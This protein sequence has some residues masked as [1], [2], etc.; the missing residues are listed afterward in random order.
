M[1]FRDSTH[2]VCYFASEDDGC[3]DYL[4]HTM[5]VVF[6]ADAEGC[7]E[8]SELLHELGHYALG[9]PMHANPRWSGLEAEFAPIVWDRPDAPDECVERYHGIRS[10]MWTVVRNS[11]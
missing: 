8:A 11:F 3:T 9:D 10:G 2:Y 4:Q 7:F 5:S 1:Q 6:P